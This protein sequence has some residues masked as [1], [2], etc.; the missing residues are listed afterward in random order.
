[1]T[2]AERL[3]VSF[4]QVHKY[5]K[6]I[7]RVGSSRLQAIAD[8]LGVSVDWFFWEGLGGLSRSQV[9]SESKNWP[10]FGENSSGIDSRFSINGA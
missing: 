6:G 4:Q 5:D 7:N 8:N 10:L 3:G 1:M 9:S 2:L